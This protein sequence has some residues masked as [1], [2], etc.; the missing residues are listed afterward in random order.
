MTA[1]CE[2]LFAPVDDDPPTRPRRTTSDECDRNSDCGGGE[3]C[4]DGEC[5]DIGEGEGEGGEGEGEGEQP[6]PLPA[7]GAVGCPEILSFTSNR[8]TITN[9][10]TAVISAVVTD[11]DGVADL[12]GGVLFDPSTNGTYG[13][14][15]ATGAGTFSIDVDWDVLDPVRSIEFTSSATRILR[16]RFFDQ[17]GLEAFADVT[18]TL[19]CDD[20]TERACDGQCGFERCNGTCQRSTSFSNDDNCGGCGVS[21]GNGFCEFNDIG[22]PECFGGGGEGEGEGGN[23]VEYVGTPEDGVKCA[24]AGTCSEECCVDIF[25]QTTLCVAGGE[26]FSGVGGSCDGPEDCD[27]ASECCF[28]PTSFNAACVPAGECREAGNSEICFNSGGCN[29]D[30]LCCTSPSAALFGLDAGICQ[31]AVDDQCP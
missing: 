18:V 27:A 31:V 30:E 3:R 28:S 13:T 6:P 23:G 10:N 7:C 22:E 19:R 11:P 20:N 15:I 14:F 29:G 5:V 4:D 1:G 21:C 8:T 26:C 17:G 12:L 24:A 2:L 9:F 25:S 16:G